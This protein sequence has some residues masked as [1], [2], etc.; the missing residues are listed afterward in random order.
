MFLTIYMYNLVNK[1]KGRTHSFL[2]KPILQC[3]DIS[4]DIEYAQTR[5]VEELKQSYYDVYTFSKH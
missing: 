2:Y 1:I 3:R 5:Q 4:R